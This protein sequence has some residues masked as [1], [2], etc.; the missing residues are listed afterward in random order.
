MAAIVIAAA[1][2]ME[3]ARR[4]STPRRWS[5]CPKAWLAS[6]AADTG[7]LIAI[8]LIGSGLLALVVVSLSAAWGI[9]E[10]MGWPHSLDLKPGQAWRFYAVY[11]AEVLPAAVVA[12]VS[13]DLVRLCIGAMVFNVVV[14]ALPLAFIVRLTSDRELL[15]DLANSRRH[16]AL[17]WAMTAVLL[18]PACSACSS[19]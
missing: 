15:G 18:G 9:G 14:L 7:W 17:L 13:A 12:L 4:R 5:S 11:F 6:R 2:A 10:L 8:G 1:A 19:I 16:T 3:S